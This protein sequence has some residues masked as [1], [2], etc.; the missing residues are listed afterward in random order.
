MSPNT[1]RKGKSVYG[2]YSGSMK[3]ADPELEK[4]SFSEKILSGN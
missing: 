1:F 4:A 2:M 3:Q